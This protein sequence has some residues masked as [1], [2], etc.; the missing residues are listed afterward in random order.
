MIKASV[1]ITLCQREWS[2]NKSVLALDRLKVNVI[3]KQNEF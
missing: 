2:S 1:F 3:P